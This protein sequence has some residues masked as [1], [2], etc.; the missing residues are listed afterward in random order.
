[1]KCRLS[2]LKEYAIVDSDD[3]SDYE[4][5]LSDNDLDTDDEDTRDMRSNT[6]SSN[7]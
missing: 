3:E 7:K 5:D 2:S 6:V 4:F 1:M